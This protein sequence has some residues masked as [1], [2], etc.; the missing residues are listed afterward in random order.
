MRKGEKMSDEQKKKISLAMIGDKNPAK[1]IEVRKR[2]SKTLK[3]RFSGKNHS[4]Y[5]KKHTKKTKKKI[6]KTLTERKL[7]KKHKSNIGKATIK[8]WDRIG[9]KTY[10]RY[11]HFCSSKK[12]KEWRMKVFVRDNFTCQFCGN[13]G[14]YL[15]A[16]H[17]KS[18]AKYPKLRYIV[19]NGTTLC[20]ENGCHKLANKIQRR[21]EKYE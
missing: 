7:S 6:S 5:G 20:V 17:N 9:R 16:H 3:G 18:W 1:R 2:I 13:R 11:I 12:Y 19:S 4:M 10:K 8:R 15:E 21:I 14:C